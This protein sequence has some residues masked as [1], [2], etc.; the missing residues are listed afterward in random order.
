MLLQKLKLARRVW[1]LK[2]FNVLQ[3]EKTHFIDLVDIFIISIVFKLS[4]SKVCSPNPS[5]NNA[6]GRYFNI[7]WTYAEQHYSA[8][9]INLLLSQVK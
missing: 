6:M 1:L 8:G 9:K 2:N 7:S 4:I 3:S 5:I